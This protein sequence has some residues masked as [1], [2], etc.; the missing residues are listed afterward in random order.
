M[1]LIAVYS[2]LI[3]ICLICSAFFSATEMCYSACNKLRLENLKDEGNKRA[4]VA[5]YIVNHYDDALSTI[6]IGNNLANIA[7]SSVATLLALEICHQSEEYTWLSTLLMT[8]AVIVFG[9]TIPKITA[10]KNANRFALDFSYIIRFLMVILFP[11]VWLIVQLI[12]IISKPFK[13]KRLGEGTDDAVEE[14]QNII[15]TAQDEDV[16]DEERTELIRSAID[17]S[18]ISASEVMTARVDVYAIDIDDSYS[19]ILKTI[20]KSPYSRIPVYEGSIDNIIGILYLNH[21]LK[22]I[23]EDNKTDIRKLLMEPIYVYKT[24]KLPDVLSKLRKAKQHL[25]V[26]CDEY[27]G[28]LGVL[29]MEDVLEEIVGEIWDDSDIVEEE[30]KERGDHEFEVDGDMNISDFLELVSI[31]ENGFEGES[32]TL[33]GW[34]VEMIGDFPKKGDSFTYDNIEVKVLEVDGRRVEKVLVKIN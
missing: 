8:V 30:V 20:E 34:T 33:G 22:A 13:G 17:F 4:K 1:T 25:A 31:R 15:E 11:V 24:M 7:G 9:E 19:G 5:Y 2:I 3:V 29:S 14:L 26:V 16:L 27:G 6:L 32:E 12:N 23:T 10:K 28:M 18:E 21:F